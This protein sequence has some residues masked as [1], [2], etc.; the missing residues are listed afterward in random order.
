VGRVQDRQPPLEVFVGRA[1]ELAR[2][3][4]V[5]ASVETGQPWLVTIEG[6]PGVGKTALARRALAG[7]GSEGFRVLSARADQAE[8]DLDFG[9]VDQWLRAA[10][11][12]SPRAAPV[13]GTGSA[14][15]SF[16][17]GAQL[18]EVV[19]AQLAVGPVVIFLDD[20]QW[21]D[22]KSVEALTFMLR[23]L[24]VDPVLAVVTYRRPL[25]RL[26]EAARRLLSSVEN[27]LP[28]MLEGLGPD[29]AA[30]LVGAIRPEPLDDEV[31]GRLYR[32]TGGHPLYLRTLLSEGSGLN[33]QAYGARAMPR[34][35]A[36]AVGDHLRGLPPE[37]RTILEM[38]AVLNLR[39]PLAQL[40]QAAQVS[41][42]SAA[43][44][45]AVAAGLVDWWPEDPV[46]PVE[47]RHLLVR[48]AIYARITATQ[49]R[50][51]HARAAMVVSEAASWEHRVA[52]LEK[53]D[54]DLAAQLEQLARDEA[55]R[56][57]LALAATH[58]QWASS[59]SPERVD[60]E[61]R[62]LTAALHLMLAEESR[63][64]A[65]REAAEATA[66]SPLRSCVLGAMAFAAGQLAE[67]ER[68]FSEA[69]AQAQ[70]DPDSQPL[71]ALIA[72]RLAGTYTLLGDGEKVMAFGQ[73]ALDTGCLD[74]AAASQTRTLVAIGASQVSGP[75]AALA[76]LTQLEADPARVGRVDID[77]LAFRGVFRLLAGD[78]QHAIADLTASLGL[79]RQGA[80]LT[81]GLRAYFYLAMAQYL[82]G[83]WDDVLLTV[84]QGFSAVAIH[85]RQF[86]LPLLHLAAV[87]VPA[88]RGAA[89][90]AESHAQLAAD[91][92]ARVD[93]SQE[94]V[95]AAMARALV[96]QATGDYLGMADALGP[97]Q[98]ASVLDGRSR[99]YAVLWRPL[100]AEGLVGSGQLEQAAA[101][102][103]QLRADSGEVSYLAPALAWL[104]GWLAEQRGDPQQALEIYRRGIDSV[105][106][107][108]ASQNE[109]GQNG[110]G[111]PVY[112]ARLLLAHGRLLRRTGQR[113][114]AVDQLRRASQEYQ[115]LRAAPFLAQAEAE[116]AT[117]LP[118]SRAGSG[119][120]AGSGS[121]AGSSS[122]VG[123]GGLA[124]KPSALALTSRETEV[125][126][127]VGKGMSNPEIAAE[128][129]VSRKAVEYHL[130]NI[131]AKCGLQGRQQL[132]RFVGEWARPAA[133]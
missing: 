42:P 76:E 9:L 28:I 5:V 68:R 63:G 20:L 12:G 30:S 18:L 127:L 55:S 34:S 98:D 31:V 45:P 83:A 114:P 95:Y 40:G 38:L 32:D 27:R 22:R 29:E 2:M 39:M 133:V 37:T 47:I 75:H 21:A 121:R 86:E 15:S 104:E 123:P 50:Q 66:P 99:M 81:L 58:L 74:P 88:G 23:R 115:A 80:T 62:L 97:W 124:G 78:L 52:A 109:V 8:A 35:L 11:A 107:N 25:D 41:S 24:S 106:Q 64:A 91:A 89:A 110:A 126:H 96:G 61:R 69:L 48:D 82:A 46:C 60:R 56:G 90:E 131:Y 7:T 19:G 105:S 85:S 57:R 120:R 17:V 128:L 33:S 73:Q 36:A 14:A 102:L 103:G 87:V 125:A 51:L 122:P 79:V 3:A 112:T 26:N 72:N 16:A 116:L 44:E 84:E 10:G 65:L 70:A 113:R 1:A 49:R 100:L 59:I 117:C 77:G 108:G 6:E 53:P 71:V 54:E 130:G 93:Y 111:S 118:A 92:A 67:A 13:G 43:I 129:F 4:Q 119:G 101:V 132:R 94:R